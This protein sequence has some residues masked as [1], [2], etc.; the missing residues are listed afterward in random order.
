MAK[1]GRQRGRKPHKEAAKSKVLKMSNVRRTPKVGMSQRTG[2]NDPRILPAVEMAY[3]DPLV[4]PL[5]PT[6]FVT[7][8]I[9]NGDTRPSKV[10][11]T[12]NRRIV[13]SRE[14]KKILTETC[15]SPVTDHAR[16]LSLMN[17]NT[18]IEKAAPAVSPQSTCVDG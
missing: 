14:L 4:R 1:A 13:P 5:C 10:T 3:S 18:A 9:A 2:R 8:R 11:G 15:A 7:N 6:S 16:T 17:G 12:A